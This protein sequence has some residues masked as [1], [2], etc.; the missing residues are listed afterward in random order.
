MHK[1]SRIAVGVAALATAGA[2][3][4]LAP[5]ANAG[6]A[7]Q[8]Y[9]IKA[10]VDCAAKTIAIKGENHSTEVEYSLNSL[11]FDATSSSSVAA[12]SNDTAKFGGTTPFRVFTE[13]E[14]LSPP[15]SVLGFEAEYINCGTAPTVTFKRT[16]TATVPS[17]GRAAAYA[18]VG[19]SATQLDTSGASGT[20]S[21]VA[22][23]GHSDRRWGFTK[24][25]SYVVPV[26]VSVTFAGGVVKSSTDN[27]R[28]TAS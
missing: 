16:G 23:T 19:G 11:T 17:G 26:T 3:F 25:G 10:N 2:A 15:R 1:H 12:T 21:G 28:V 13:N 14:S 7:G 24:S 9:D 20:N 27:L 6:I 22:T 8:H 4:A 18:N 5:A